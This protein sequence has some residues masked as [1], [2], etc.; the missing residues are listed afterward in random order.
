VSTKSSKFL[1][2][3]PR[4]CA[5]QRWTLNKVAPPVGFALSSVLFL[6][7]GCL[8][9]S[10]TSL[11]VLPAA[12]TT[13]AVAG[14][15]SQFQALATYTESNHASTTHDVT[16]QATWQSSTLAVATISSTGLATGISAGTAAIS[17]SI[18]GPFGT[19]V[20][21]S[22]IAVTV[23]PPL[24]VLTALNVTPG[25]QTITAKGQTAQLIAI[26]TYNA[27][28]L[29]QNLSTTVAWQSSNAQVATVT[30]SGLVSGVGIGQTT[31]TALATASDGSTVSGVAAISVTTPPSGRI[32]TAL[33]V[34]PGSQTIT[35]TGQT[36]Q[37][38]AIGTYS[39]AP[40]TQNLSATVTWQSSDAQ[41][42]TVASS[43]LVSSVGI[44]QTTVTALATAS[45]DSIISGSAAISVTTAPSGR[46][47]TSLSVI[48]PSQTVSATGET[49]QY[50][51][52]GT[53]SAAPLTMDLTDQV[54][55]QSSDAQVG[56]VNASGLVT[57]VGPV[58]L[59]LPAIATITALATASDGSVIPASATFQEASTSVVNL[60]TL[61]V[62]KVGNGTGT[63]TAGT[64]LS[65]PPSSVI[66]ITGTVV[67]TCGTGTGCIGNFP[68]NTPVFLVADAL[69]GSVFD[70]WS[71]NCVPVPG[72]P[73][74]VCTVTMTNNST[75]GA[76]FDPTQ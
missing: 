3:Q 16:D 49:A 55:W 57:G 45:D 62:Y 27:A 63:V 7:A 71:V 40:L 33:T 8:S 67:I 13:T 21:A 70:G 35:A 5:R 9:K 17:A 2:S 48:P 19:V 56:Q 24:R 6:L 53:Y 4:A 34:S 37:L 15:T 26:G 76:I 10:L 11:Q 23:G 36:A 60:P 59:V 61:T 20:G 58:V 28:P 68:I 39:A 41:V 29:T 51:A 50:I 31:I 1:D 69:S 52:V 47:L 32:L 25:S 46:I 75:V 72:Y 74:N 22:N 42:A 38:I 18:Q 30:S 14:Q 65:T 54:A 43:G 44:G 73:P 64:A 12:G 66:T